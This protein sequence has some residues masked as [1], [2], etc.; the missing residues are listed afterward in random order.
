K[1][2]EEET[3]LKSYLLLDMSAS[4]G[5]TSGV[6]TKQDYAGSLAAALAYLNLKQ[7]DAAGLVIFDEA[8]RSYIP[9]GS[10]G[11]HLNQLLQE[12]SRQQ[13]SDK[14]DIAGALHRMA[15]RIKRRGL[16]VLISDLLDDPEEIV[17]GLRHFRHNRHEVIVF[18]VVDP[19]ERDFSF[20]EEAVF[21]DMETGEEITTLPWQIK[22]SYSKAFVDFSNY[23]SL[24]CSE[25]R[26]D[27]HLIDTS[28][29]FDQALYAFLGKRA[30]LY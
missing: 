17:S 13:T 16:V 28:T 5:Y 2:Y 4:M 24:R 12:I 18:H 26:I 1:Q 20:T 19:R 29:P 27:Y 23:I 9:P 11:G 3:N 6:I 21:K 8:I 22:K 15:D 7:R 25:S 10:K 30:R 14:T